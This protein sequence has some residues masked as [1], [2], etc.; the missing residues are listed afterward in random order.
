MTFR[1]NFLGRFEDPAVKESEIVQNLA[2]IGAN[3]ETDL[4]L[5]NQA[6]MQSML[7]LTFM[8]ENEL[9]K[10]LAY[11]FI[12]V[13]NWSRATGFVSM[14]L[15]KST[16]SVVSVPRGTVLLTKGG[17]SYL[18]VSDVILTLNQTLEVPVEQGRRGSVSGIYSDFIEIHEPQIDLSTTEVKINGVSIP[19]L[20][21][22]NAYLSNYINGKLK[23]YV[24]EDTSIEVDL[25]SNIL[26][27]L[28]RVQ[29]S[30]NISPANGYAQFVFD[31]VCYIKIFSGQDIPILEGQPFSV[32]YINTDGFKAN[33]NEN[34]IIK[35]DFSI[36]DGNG[37]PAT[38]TL[39]NQPITNGMNAPPK[40][41]L[42]NVWKYWLFVKDSVT[43]IS[44]Y[45]IFFRTQPEVGDVIVR[46]D[47]EKWLY[48]TEG[49]EVPQNVSGVV[50]VSL[51]SKQI[52]KLS[53]SDLAII[54][55]RLES[56]K[57]LS[58]I[59]Y[60]DFKE[61]FYWF[62]IRIKG[63]QDF[64]LFRSVCID[65]ISRYFDI[66]FINDMG[67][68][69]FDP[70]DVSLIQRSISFP[71]SPVGFDIIPYIYI[72]NNITEGQA[73]I[74]L[75]IN[76]QLIKRNAFYKFIYEKDGEEVI[77]SFYEEIADRDTSWIYK[78]G[79]D[80]PVGVH[81]YKSN[82]IIINGFDEEFMFLHNGVFKAYFETI[83]NS[84]LE[85]DNSF[86]VRRLVGVDFEVF[87]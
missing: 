66:T 10:F 37:T 69:L 20:N 46:G 45:N 75:V 61:V 30:D 58:L 28:R 21:K 55:A 63:V 84:Y 54:S 74:Q 1:D 52:T 7:D 68:S 60:F 80:K 49:E 16:T 43:K 48:L 6:Y 85:M 41:E 65:R 81:N 38:I 8:D 35:F 67:G 87:K 25:K 24:E 73:I 71:D 62:L 17:D 83:N 57:D 36:S 42:L 29:D 70:L 15:T 26:D 27:E 33:A 12:E 78:E 59:K 56:I 44:D 53:Q 5:Q 39:S 13:R 72:Q 51:V 14:T 19:K 32:N 79:R 40:Y 4:I 34:S 76:S 50:S 9:R 31:D 2:M 77:E 22:K 23:S 86:Y 64:N 82:S 11:F 47:Y 18:T 3:L